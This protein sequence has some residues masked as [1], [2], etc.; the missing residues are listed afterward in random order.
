MKKQLTAKQRQDKF[1][2]V[3]KY[4]DSTGD[5]VA[6]VAEVTMSSHV[7]VNAWRSKANAE[8]TIPARPFAMLVA[9]AEKAGYKI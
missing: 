1:L 8:Y 5:G 7:T 6:W 4:F 2:S 3:F 9:A